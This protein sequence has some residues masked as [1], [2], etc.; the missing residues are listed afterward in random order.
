[1]CELAATLPNLD[2]SLSSTGQ[3]LGVPFAQVIVECLTSSKTETRSAAT[4]LL[5]VVLGNRVI[6]AENFRKAV[7]KLVPA[8]QRTVGPL[9]AKYAGT[10]GST[11][12]AHATFG[13]PSKSR[14]VPARTSTKLSAARN[15]KDF[16]SRQ[17]QNG[18]APMANDRAEV[19]RHPLQPKTNTMSLPTCKGLVWPEYPE[20]PQ[21]TSIYLNLKKSW[22][23]ILSAK[24]FAALFPSTGIRK[25]DEAKDGCEL[26]QKAL[27]LDREAGYTH[28]VQQL[29]FILKWTVFSLC[30]RET[31]TGLQTLLVFVKELLAYLV[32]SKHELSD[33]E[34]LDFVPYLI[35]RASNAKVCTW[36]LLYFM[37]QDCF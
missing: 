29:D 37:F 21:G 26:L 10:E 4:G 18:I 22:S 34:A 20:E 28:V 11:P 23:Q 14:S 27:Q 1:L 17:P 9:V 13:D 36:L 3:P 24:S 33:S 12:Q 16:S 15:Q 35:D 8:K 30:S 6:G 2:E 5:E 32:D 25:Q 7:G 31:T 19:H